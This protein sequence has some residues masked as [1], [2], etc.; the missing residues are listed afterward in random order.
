[1]KAM[2][3]AMYQQCHLRKYNGDQCNIEENINNLRNGC[4]MA[5][6]LMAM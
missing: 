3:A 2:A 5:Q 1:M 6:W 4:E